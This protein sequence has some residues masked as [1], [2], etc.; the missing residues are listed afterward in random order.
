MGSASRGVRIPVGLWEGGS[1]NATVATALLS[2]LV[3]R[4]LDLE[5]GMPFVLDGPR[6]LR[7]AVRTVSGEVPV[8]RCARHEGRNV[9][10]HL[11]ERDRPPVLARCGAWAQTD[12][13]RRLSSTSD[14][15]A[16]GR[17]HHP[18]VAN[19]IGR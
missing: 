11:A 10:R 6:A 14:R 5:Q 8:P 19:P 18:G 17:P 16:A 4:G 9:I 3:G 15:L 1:E 7:E 2:G 13:D 12:Y